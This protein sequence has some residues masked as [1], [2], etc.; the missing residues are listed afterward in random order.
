MEGF[1][2]I[3]NF[4]INDETVEKLAVEELEAVDPQL[5]TAEEHIQQNIADSIV[6]D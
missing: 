4:L 2:T 1:N 5:D 6:V 3:V